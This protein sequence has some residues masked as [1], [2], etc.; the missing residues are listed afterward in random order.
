MNR[1][2]R[3]GRKEG[4]K[5]IQRPEKRRKGVRTKKLWMEG[6]GEKEGNTNTRKEE[7]GCRNRETMH[8]G[9]VKGARTKSAPVLTHSLRRIPTHGIRLIPGPNDGQCGSVANEILVYLNVVPGGVRG[10]RR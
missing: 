7:E 2:H 8:G 9:E 1:Q 10:K 4:R 6:K 5:E 3:E